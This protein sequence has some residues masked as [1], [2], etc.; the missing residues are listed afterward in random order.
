MYSP[1]IFEL[2]NKSG[3]R[4]TATNFGGK[5]ISLVVPDRNGHL[6]DVVLG[7][8]TLGQYAVGNPFFG[9]LIGRFANRIAKGSFELDGNIYSLSVNNGGNSLHGG[10]AGFHNVNWKTIFVDT[11]KIQLSYL[12][13]HNEEGFPGNVDVMVTYQLT[14]SNEFI[15]DYRATTDAPTLVN[16]T[17]HSFF[18]LAGAGSADILSHELLIDADKFCPVDGNLIPTGELLSVAGSSFDFKRPIAIGKNINSQEQQLIFA[19]GYDHNWVLNKKNDE[20]SLAAK[21]NEPIS[22]RVM[23]VFTTEPGLQFY[24]GNFLDG[25]DIGK[26]EKK[27]GYRSAFC[28]EAQHFPDSPN[29]PNFPS[30]VLKP[31]EM[32]KQRTWTSF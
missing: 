30:T 26:G 17:H 4:L 22:G 25:T 20:L 8:D 10:H 11:Q 32:Y 21:V 27:Y 14:D 29:Q 13:T 9:A 18:N 12:S 1:Q 16:L 6:D 15:I 24:S 3:L 23:E 7:Y 5:V 2:I 31:G 28:L 19:K